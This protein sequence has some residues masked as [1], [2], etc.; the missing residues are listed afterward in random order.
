MDFDWLALSRTAFAQAWQVTTL[1]VFV[2]VLTRL[3]ARNRPHLAYVLWL[4]VLL[5][6][7]TPPLW[8]SP[9]GA[10]T[11]MQSQFVEAD[12]VVTTG[13]LDFELPDMAVLGEDESVLGDADDLVINLRAAQTA[14]VAA[15]DVMPVATRSGF[16]ATASMFVAA[17]WAV[18][19][20][21]ALIVSCL[22]WRRCLRV[23]R[24]TPA[25]RSPEIESLLAD[26]SA[27]LKVGRP[28]QLLVTSSYFGPAV[29]GLL[30][31]L[32]VLPEVIVSGKSAKEL[33]AFLAHELIHVRRGDLWLGL[34][35]VCAK[36]VW[37]F[38]PVVSFACRISTRE[39]ERC[40]DEEVIGALQCDPKRY[41]LS[42]LHVLEL[43]R[44][45]QPVPAFPGMKPV[46]VTTQRLERIMKL[47]QGCHRNTP[48]WCWAIMLLVS[49]AALPGAA[50]I[51]ADEV[52][53]QGVVG[54]A[55]QRTG[56]ALPPRP[57]RPKH[58]P[59]IGTQL[60]PMTASSYQAR[61]VLAALK[62]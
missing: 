17:I 27:K 18:G 41:A 31:P 43:K 46:E 16:A 7:V 2:L 24:R 61:Q 59:M 48:R 5:K 45:L 28:V 53:K 44:T 32:I 47:G 23:L 10:Y 26:L 8:S 1:I 3:V 14:S 60:A 13:H 20:A 15:T 57:W 11:W 52:P 50:F 4:V 56:S 62:K 9:T 42:L 40:C 29:I 34:L 49:A 58:R 33:E 35:Q 37:W 22:R 54:P 55:P 19:F 38:Y 36:A 39:A 12:P 30:R 51:A 25:V 6:C 21:L